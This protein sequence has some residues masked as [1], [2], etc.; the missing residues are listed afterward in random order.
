LCPSQKLRCRALVIIATSSTQQAHFVICIACDI[1]RKAGSSSSTTTT[2]AYY[3]YYHLFIPTAQP[4]P[5]Q[6]Y[7]YYGRKLSVENG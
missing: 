4:P 7:Y 6:Q 1:E 3:Y 2:Q 5:Q